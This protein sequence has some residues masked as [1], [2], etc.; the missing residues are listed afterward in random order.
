MLEKLLTSGIRAACL[1]L[2]FNSPDEKFYV[3]EIARLLRKNPSGVQRELKK[4]ETMGLVRS[5]R[6]GN[7]RYY[8]VYR[9]SPLFPELKGLIAKSLGLPGALKAVL[10]ASGIKVAFIY[11]PYADGED[12]LSIDLFIVS[13]DTNFDKNLAEVERRFGREISYTLMNE[14]DYRIKKKRGEPRL[15]KLLTGKKILLLGKL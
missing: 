14:S 12:A 6:E 5:E 10:N 11:G 15:R 3:R 9:D 13:N 2:L 4:L 1:S 7:L 8:K